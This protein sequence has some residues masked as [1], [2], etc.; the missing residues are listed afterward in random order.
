MATNPTIKKERPAHLPAEPLRFI[1]GAKI[2]KNEVVF[3]SSEDG[4]LYPV[5]TRRS[6]VPKE[7][8][9]PSWPQDETGV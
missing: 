4:K 8:D 2:E 5:G 3:L 9:S 1:A 6:L 7:E